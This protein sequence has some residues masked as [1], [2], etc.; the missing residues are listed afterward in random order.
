MTNVDTAIESPVILS[1]C[2]GI[3]GLET[4]LE[5]ALGCKPHVAAFLENEAFIIENLLAAMEHGILVPTPVWTDVRT[6]PYGAFHGRI[7]GFVG[8]Y[9]C[10]P[11]SLAGHRRG[12]D[13]HRHLWPFICAGIKAARPVW[14]YFENVD[15]HLT[16]GYDTVYKD[17]RELGYLVESGIYSA[18]EVGAPHERQ[19]LY[20]FAIRQEMAY[21]NGYD[22]GRI[23]DNVL[24]TER[25]SVAKKDQ[26]QRHRDEPG[27]RGEAVAHSGS[28]RIHESGSEQQSELIEPDGIPGRNELEDTGS[29]RGKRGGK[30]SAGRG[31]RKGDAAGSG[32]EVGD[33][34][35]LGQQGQPDVNG[36][37][38]ETSGTGERGGIVRTD[39]PVGYWPAGQGPFQYP[40]E[41]PRTVESGMVYNVNGYGFM[42]DLHRAIGNSVV[43]QTAKKALIDLVHKH[44]KTMKHYGNR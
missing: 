9:P 12:A 10:Q 20:I 26:R 38:Q 13:D 1:L 37:N 18:E 19:R 42:G 2:T 44:I 17:L 33:T 22:P 41:P 36:G 3:R 32:R 29:Q 30:G 27:S 5:W 25:E 23:I 8:G 34:Q 7:H 35:G 43:P 14:C 11:F 15:D 28:I 40:Y 16:M 6:F 24:R 21:A 31:T 4:G 39:T